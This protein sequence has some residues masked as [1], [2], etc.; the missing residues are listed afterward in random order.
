MSEAHGFVLHK[1]SPR[2]ASVKQKTLGESRVTPS[3]DSVRGGEDEERMRSVTLLRRGDSAGCCGRCGAGR[4]GPPTDS[5]TAKPQ[6]RGWH[7]GGL[8][9]QTADRPGCILSFI[10]FMNSH[11]EQCQLAHGHRAVAEMARRTGE[12]Q[13]LASLPVGKLVSRT[14]FSTT[15]REL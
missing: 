5:A 15:T 7:R 12:S 9:L 10:G 3:R 1:L 13:E 4:R 8:S 6:G 2:N 11:T 14:P